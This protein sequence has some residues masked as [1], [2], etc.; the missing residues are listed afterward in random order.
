MRSPSSEQSWPSR[1][2]IL[3]ELKI[4][5]PNAD[6]VIEGYVD[7]RE[8]SGLLLNPIQRRR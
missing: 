7:P 6:F 8:P 2:S 4:A 3:P 5:L 1:E